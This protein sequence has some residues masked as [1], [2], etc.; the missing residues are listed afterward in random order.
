V[1]CCFHEH[2]LLPCKDRFGDVVWRKP[3][4]PAILGVLK[5]PAYAGAFVYGRSRAVPRARAPHEHV[6]KPL[7]IAE[8][9][10]CHK[11]K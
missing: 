1:V 8:W 2:E 11:D 7:P 9:K 4:V 10:I 6:Q 3:T 5:N